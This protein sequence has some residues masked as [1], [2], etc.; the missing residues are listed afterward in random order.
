[1]KRRVL[2][3]KYYIQNSFFTIKR[4][5]IFDSIA[6]FNKGSPCRQRAA[7]EAL[8]RGTLWPQR[9]AIMIRFNHPNIG[10]S[11]HMQK[12]CWRKLRLTREIFSVQSRELYLHRQAGSANH[13]ATEKHSQIFVSRQCHG[14]GQSF[15]LQSKS[16][17]VGTLDSCSQQHKKSPPFA[18]GDSV[19]DSADRA[20]GWRLE[21]RL[22]LEAHLLSLNSASITSS[23]ALLEPAAEPLPPGAAP[24]PSAAAAFWYTAA[25][26]A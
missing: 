9:Y 17:L 12:T 8:H 18:D 7:S 3:R 23:A 15:S 16:C 6:A 22:S 5:P 24:L 13:L 19:L 25:P 4:Y 26:A 20:P 10:R 2:E 14:N 1:M 11:E 21:S